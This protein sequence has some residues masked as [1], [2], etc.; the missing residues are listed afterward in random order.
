VPACY[1]S[2]VRSSLLLPPLTFLRSIGTGRYGRKAETHGTVLEYIH[3]RNRRLGAFAAVAA[4][5]SGKH[6]PDEWTR[7]IPGNQRWLEKRLV[8]LTCSILAVVA[9]SNSARGACV[10][11]GV[12]SHK[13]FSTPSRLA[14]RRKGRSR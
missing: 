7:H 14:C 9:R 1:S 10:C 2:T 3:A 11:A 13:S 6:Q 5:T 8:P 4:A 12:A